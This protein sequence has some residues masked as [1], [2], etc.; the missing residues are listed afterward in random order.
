MTQSDDVLEFID[1]HPN[2]TRLDIQY[3]LGLSL[4]EVNSNIAILSAY[5]K[6]STKQFE[7]PN[8]FVTVRK[9]NV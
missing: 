2:C 4:S 7:F 8:R 9:K 1:A 5:R 6:I 3:A